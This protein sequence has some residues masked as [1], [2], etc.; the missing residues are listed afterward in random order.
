M[1]LC[2]PHANAY[3]AV[4]H[5]ADPG[6]Q[7]VFQ[8]LDTIPD[9]ENRVIGVITKCDRKQEGAETWVIATSTKF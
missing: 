5:P 1:H 4:A 8:M 7:E 6:T 2:A 9:K 3:R